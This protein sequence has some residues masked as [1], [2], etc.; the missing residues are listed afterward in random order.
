MILPNQNKINKTQRMKVFPNLTLISPFITIIWHDPTCPLFKQARD[1]LLD[2]KV[3]FYSYQV[4]EKIETEMY[5]EDLKVQCMF[6][7]YYNL[8]REGLI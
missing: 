6:D 5:I 8:F 7:F 4:D 3:P 1:V 2:Y